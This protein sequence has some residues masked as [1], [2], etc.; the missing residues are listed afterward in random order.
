MT[1]LFTGY[2]KDKDG[3]LTLEDF[4]TFYAH[5]SRGERP[6]V[7]RDNLEAFNVRPDLRKWAEVGDEA[8]PDVD[9]LPRHFMARDQAHFDQLMLLLDQ[10]N[11]EVTK[12]VWE[13]VQMLATNPSYYRKVLQ[14]DIAKRGAAGEVDWA[15]FFDSSSPYRLLYTLQIVQAVLEDGEAESSRAAALNPEVF[16]SSRLR[17]R[18]LVQ[19]SATDEEGGA[20]K[21]GPGGEA[22]AA[23]GRPS[24]AATAQEEMQLRAQWAEE[25]LSEGGFQYILKDFM[26]CELPSPAS[27][28][29]KDRA[30]SRELKYVAFMLHL[31][32][33]FIMAAFST[34]DADAYQIA[35]LARRNS[36]KS[37]VGAQQQDEAART[38]FQ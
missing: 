37:D 38:S 29:S 7:V 17:G 5:A 10:E 14:L 26:T 36:S 31:L 15:K 24:I 23:E 13:L 19:A 32:R 18:A 28:D 9:E 27:P 35:A 1:G 22:G 21:D 12:A 20:Q 34:S 6:G 11:G 4:L 25:F 3:K 2:D 30:E 33:S 8:S 16:P